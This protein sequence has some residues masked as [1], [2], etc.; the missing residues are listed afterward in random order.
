MGSIA[1]IEISGYGTIASEGGLNRKKTVDTMG[2]YNQFLVAR[3][4]NQ[5]GQKDSQ[6]CTSNGQKRQMIKCHGSLRRFAENT[7]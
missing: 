3:G 7:W 5:N 4:W 1:I 6:P 2:L